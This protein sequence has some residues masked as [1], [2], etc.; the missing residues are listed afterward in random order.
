MSEE[1]AGKG[2]SPRNCFSEEFRNNYD[3]IFGKETTPKWMKEI[4]YRATSV[5]I[6]TN[7]EFQDLVNKVKNE[8]KNAQ[9]HEQD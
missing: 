3:R 2:D 1:G 5:P 8:G 6:V 7:D 9:L 4:Q